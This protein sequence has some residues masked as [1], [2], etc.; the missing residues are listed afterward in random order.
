MTPTHFAIRAAVAARTARDLLALRPDDV[1]LA[2]FPKTGSSWVRSIVSALAH[3]EAAGLAEIDRAVPALGA[4][5][6]AEPW[7]GTVPRLIKTHHP[8][9][10]VLFARP[11][12]SVLL[13]RD[14]RDTLS[15]Y[16]HMLSHRRVA[17]FEGSLAAF[18]R[19]PRFGIEAYL[20][21]FSSWAPRATTIVRYETLRADPA[22]TVVALFEALGTPLS[23]DRAAEAVE[24][25]S[26][27]RMK[28]R[29]ATSG[30]ANE[31]RFD[32]DFAF[33]RSGSRRAEAERFS[34]DD[35]ALY[36]R[37]RSEAGFDLYP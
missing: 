36:Q 12:R 9:R 26:L 10:P 29:E 30:I 6:V 18:V 33:V 32:D 22:P 11:R 3:G 35:E 31:T 25:S 17:R 28:A 7:G 1:W 2:T 5:T 27:E 37:L 8:Y 21:H 14:P 4:G 15:S 13:I 16:H 23:L 24:Q 34:A 20:R 19:D